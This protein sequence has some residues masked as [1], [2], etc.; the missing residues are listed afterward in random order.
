MTGYVAVLF[1]NVFSAGTG[2][3]WTLILVG[4]ENGGCSVMWKVMV[5]VAPTSMRLMFPRLTIGAD[6]FWTFFSIV[7]TTGT[8]TSCASPVSLTAT[9]KARLGEAVI[10]VSLVGESCSPP[11]STLVDTSPTP[12]TPVGVEVGVDAPWTRCQTGVIEAVVARSVLLKIF[13]WGTETP[14]IPC[15]CSSRSDGLRK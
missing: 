7:R 4:V 14:V 5:W 10:V 1:E 13:E 3:T 15:R 2:P 9:S 11:G 12:C 6:R 8:F